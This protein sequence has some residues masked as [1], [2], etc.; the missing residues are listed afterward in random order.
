MVQSSDLKQG[1]LQTQVLT[2]LSAHI[3]NADNATQSSRIRHTGDRL[4][5][6]VSVD[7]YRNRC[8]RGQVDQKPQMVER[9]L[10]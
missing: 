1:W 4:L 6:P 3:A 7:Q 10:D 8:L 9:I 5:C 2:L